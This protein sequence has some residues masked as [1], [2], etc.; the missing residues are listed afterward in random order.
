[1]VIDGTFYVSSY[2]ALAPTCPS[3]FSGE[4]LVAILPFFT[5]AEYEIFCFPGFRT[6]WSNSFTGPW[7][8]PWLIEVRIHTSHS[9]KWSVGVPPIMGS[10]LARVLSCSYHLDPS[11][12]VY[13]CRSPHDGEFSTLFLSGLVWVWLLPRHRSFPLFGLWSV[14]WRAFIFMF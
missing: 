12:I 1:L 5:F 9:Y 4:V 6:F 10:A 2:S 11:K 14:R 3:P 8:P 7:F 13:L